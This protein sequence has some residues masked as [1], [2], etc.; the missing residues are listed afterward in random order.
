[1]RTVSLMSGTS[2]D[3]VDVAVADWH[4]DGETLWLRP[5]GTRGLAY[6]DD[7]R[8][9]IAAVLPPAASGVEAVCR[10]DARLG[11]VFADAAAVGLELAG[12]RA[13]LVVS[14]GQTVFHWVDG[15]RARGTLQLGAPAWIARRTGLPVLSDL[16]TADIAA[17]GQ[18]APLVPAFD[19][20]L[21]AEDGRVGAAAEDGRV[22]AALG[23][24][25]GGAT[26]G[27]PPLARAAL[28]LGGIANLTVV[29]PPAP[30]LGYDIGPANA[31]IDAATLRFHGEPYDIDGRRATA[32]RVHEGLLARLLAEP[33]YAAP[34]PKSTGKEL[35]HAG[36]LDRHLSAVAGPVPGDDVIATVTELTA[37]A[38]AAACDRHRVTE[39]IA[40]G[41]GVR[42]PVLTGRLADLG[43]GRWRLRLSDEFGV[44][45]QAKEAYAF[46]LLGWLSWHGLPGS[47]PSVTGAA[48]PAVLGCW[49]AAGWP[50]PAPT[51][52]Q[53][54][55][56][57]GPRRLRV[58]P[59]P[60]SAC[61]R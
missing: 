47:L 29:A 23:D 16:R 40:A 4:R 33:Y 28:N 10:L 13:D 37:R 55:A 6:D 46:G 32:G 60:A 2:Y 58:A 48:E 57:P 31:L 11:Q 17:G 54:A 25:P 3:G 39:V 36:Y 27:G 26:A 52:R 15:G 42:N 5:V 19:A 51:S 22:G 35:F 34:P 7:L 56:D 21:L 8:A 50:A 38:V 9:A 41:G 44:P 53:P 18:G 43:A 1:M 61:P 59:A 30:V 20:L 49:T 14:P 45:A 24:G 12:G